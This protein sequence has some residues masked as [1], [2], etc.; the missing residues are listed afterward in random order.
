GEA[1]RAARHRDRH[2]RRAVGAGEVAELVENLDGDRR[3]NSGAGHGGGGLHVEGEVVGRAWGDIERTRRG[4][5]QSAVA[6]RQRVARADLIDGQAAEGRDAAD[7]DDGGR[8]AQRAAARVGADG[9][10]DTRG[11]GGDEVV[12]LVE[13]PHG[14]GRTDGGAGA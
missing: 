12:E 14:Y 11:V 3:A 10:T 8:A 9:H 2:L 4:A 7:G 5:G 6:R 13:D 1:A